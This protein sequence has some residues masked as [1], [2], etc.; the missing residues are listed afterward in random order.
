MQTMPEL[1]EKDIADALQFVNADDRD[2]WVSMAMAVKSE[3]GDQGFDVWDQWS[4]SSGQYK[5]RDARHVWKSCKAHG[6]VTIGTLLFEA[7]QHG[8]VL[9]SNDNRMTPEQLEER[10]RV[11]DE[12]RRQSQAEQ[13]QREYDAAMLAGEIWDAASECADHPYLERKGVKPHGLRVGSWPLRNK[14]GEIYAHAENALLVPLRN[15]GSK[16][17]TLQAV[18]SQLPP[19]YETDK[20]FL[21]D[22]V[23]SGSWHTIGDF[24][25]ASTVALCEGYA[26]GATI[27][28]L[29]GWC[30]LVCFDRTNL[31]PVG[32][33]IKQHAD[34]KALIVCADNDRHTFGNPGI[35][36]AKATGSEIGARVLIPEFADEDSGSGTDFNDLAN[37]EGSNA[38]RTQLTGHQAVKAAKLPTPDQVDF[39]TPLPDI[40]STGKPMA[41]IENLDAIVARLGVTIRYN[42]IKKEQ[43]ILIPGESFLIDNEANAAHAWLESWCARFRMSAGN[44]GG[45][46]TYLADKNP[47][48][49]VATWIESKPWDGVTRLPALFD[50]V[51]T[52]TD[53]RTPSGERLRDVL[54]RRWMISAVAAAFSPQGVSAHG[55]LTFQ[56]A[57]YLGKTFWLKRLV[58]EFLDVVQDGMI[59]KPDD[60]DSVKQICSFWIAE[61]GELDATFRKSDIAA[62]KSFITKKNDM[63]RLP[64]ARKDS[65]FARRTVFFASVNPKEF[66]HDPTGNRR[67][68]S[69]DVEWLDLEHT[70]NMQQVWAEVLELYRAGVSHYLTKEEMETLNGSNE[71]FQVIDPVEERIQTRLNWDAQPIEWEWR[72]ATD[73]LISVGIDKPTQAD[74]TKAA[75][76]I[77]KMNGDQ[78]KRSNG[79]NLMLV[80]PVRTGTA[81]QSPW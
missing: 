18:F 22:G 66:L 36:A 34:G 13:K 51:K 16:L 74:A 54:I 40:N 31:L 11:R 62:L 45:F 26:T 55:I 78:G 46:I 63:L 47:H 44:L 33:K 60:R 6:K 4:Q 53:K 61:L 72:T 2:L 64:Y 42:V 56:G 35:T 68:W 39:Y 77:R 43:E 50:T 49:P 20:A 30:V 3:L 80:P 71:S 65:R 73:V 9:A 24:S 67:Y 21:R 17:T 23:K 58:P 1:T 59:L 52:K 25:T 32:K 37:A 81:S 12:A 28:E 75:H 10:Q 69:I 5:E 57:Q 41:T 27:H 29:T 14:Q 19:G 7:Q 48:N 70:I 79:R 8:F 76:S 38:A 15:S